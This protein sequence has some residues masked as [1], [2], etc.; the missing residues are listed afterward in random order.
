[1][2]FLFTILF[3]RYS[4]KYSTKIDPYTSGKFFFLKKFQMIKD[5]K[6]GVYY[7]KKI[8]ENIYLFSIKFFLFL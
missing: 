4:Y 7:D 5:V 6:D 1:M 8:N 2:S 3:H